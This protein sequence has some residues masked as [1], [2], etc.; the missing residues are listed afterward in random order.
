ML[1]V[2]IY[3]LLDNKGMNIFFICTLLLSLLEFS[4]L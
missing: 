3:D 2:R 4:I 1:Y